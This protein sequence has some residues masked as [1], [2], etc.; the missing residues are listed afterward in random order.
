V[1][2]LQ[3]FAAALGCIA[4]NKFSKYQRL[5][6][7]LTSAES[8]W[9]LSNPADRVVVFSERLETLRWLHG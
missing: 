2:D 8:G 9:A 4:A 6:A 7:Y 1:E 5:L 3:A